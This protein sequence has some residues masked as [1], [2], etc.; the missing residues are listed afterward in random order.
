MAK[1]E[2]VGWQKDGR[3]YGGK[4]HP[5]VF[6]LLFDGQERAVGRADMLRMIKLSLPERPG[7]GTPPLDPVENGS[8]AGP[9]S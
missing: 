5:E 8:A 7:R 2:I 4:P 6:Y 1:L 9:T 3:D